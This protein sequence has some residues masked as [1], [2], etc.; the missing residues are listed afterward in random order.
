ML[1]FA[2]Y[3]TW[4]CK[5]VMLRQATADGR[6]INLLQGIAL[7]RFL[8]LR[9]STYGNTVNFNIGERPF[10]AVPR[11]CGPFRGDY[12]FT[13]TTHGR[14][15]TWGA[16]GSAQ[17]CSTTNSDTNPRHRFKAPMHETTL[18]VGDVFQL[19]NSSNLRMGS[20]WLATAITYIWLRNH[21]FKMV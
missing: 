5:G 3:H 18:G 12:T 20:Q 8:T 4:A 7:I 15:H 16:E 21:P 17:L 14:N 9:E 6:M 2:L 1:V 13:F 11:P 10:G 19:R